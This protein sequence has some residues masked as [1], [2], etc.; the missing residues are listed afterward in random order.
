VDRFNQKRWGISYKLTI[1]L[2]GILLILSTPVLADWWNNDWE[3]KQEIVV[4][5]A[6]TETLFN[7]TFNFT[8]PYDSNMQNDFDDIRFVNETGDIVYPYFLG[9]KTDSSNAEFFVRINETINTGGLTIYMYYGNTGATSLSDGNNTFLFFHDAETGIGLATTIT[10]TVATT[11][12]G[13]VNQKTT[14]FNSSS[15]GGTSRLHYDIPSSWE[16]PQNLKVSEWI[17]DPF[18]ADTGIWT[19]AFVNL[20]TQYLGCGAYDL[21]DN[22]YRY[23]DSAGWKAS[24]S[25]AR[26]EGWKLVEIYDSDNDNKLECYVNGCSVGE[27][28]DANKSISLVYYAEYFN[29]VGALRKESYADFFSIKYWTKE[30]TQPSYSFGAEQTFL[31]TGNLSVG[32]HE[33][34][35]FPAD[36]S[37][38]LNCSFV[39]VDTYDGFDMN[40]SVMWYRDNIATINYTLNNSYANNTA[41]ST[42]LTASNTSV[43]QNWTCGITLNAGIHIGNQ[44]NVSRLISNAIP[45][46]PSNLNPAN[47]TLLDSSTI[48]LSCSGSTDEDGDSIYYEFYGDSTATPTTLLQNTTLTS[49]SWTGL[50]QF[51]NYNWRCRSHDRKDV[52]A[53]TDA[54]S[55]IAGDILSFGLCSAGDD[56]LYINFTSFTDEGN[57]TNLTSDFRATFNVGTNTTTKPLNYSFNLLDYNSTA[58]CFNSTATF[59]TDAIVEYESTGYEKREYYFDNFLMQSGFVHDITL[60]NINEDDGEGILITV[61]DNL[62]DPIQDAIIEVQKYFVG[63][64]TYEVVAMGNTDDNGQDYLFLDQA[65]TFYRFIIIQDNE[66]I[67]TSSLQKI[68]LSSL[69]ISVVPAPI[70]ETL[71]EFAGVNSILSFSNTTRTF[72]D[73]FTDTQG[74][75]SNNCLMVTRPNLFN[76]TTVICNTCSTLASSTL[77]CNIGSGSGTYIAIHKTEINNITRT[78]NILVHEYEQEMR[79]LIKDVSGVGGVGIAVMLF[80]FAIGIAVISPSISVLMMMVMVII[81]F[82][83]GFFQI[84]YLGMIGILVGG[85]IYLMKLK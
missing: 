67:F 9:N 10:G 8:I 16:F 82:S 68:T 66:V 52:S 47:N 13:K 12:T 15:A 3:R 43:N 38:D 57:L 44:S 41:V 80:I 32:L 79:G 63:S 76:Q 14:S 31:P 45:T 6:G 58:L 4:S 50:N 21:D 48:L 62:D 17:Y 74:V 26:S 71:G 33:I 39:A 40:V 49:Y 59:Y 37:D 18:I 19:I 83:M 2:I 42:I 27:G 72:T 1:L 36:I 5:Y 25:C 23:S 46:V 30:G 35:P 24:N 70:G 77:T 84:G 61:V 34:N 75:S 22:F 65:E 53:F 78:I 51:I 73:V 64:N 11:T 29:S 60:Y 69:T 54:R 55:L 56:T 81:S 20:D 85:V 28:A 7:F